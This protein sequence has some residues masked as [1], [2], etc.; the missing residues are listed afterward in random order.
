MMELGEK[1]MDAKLA[2]RRIKNLDKGYIYIS[3]YKSLNK[4]TGKAFEKLLITLKE[5][6]DIN[7]KTIEER[8]FLRNIKMLYS[9]LI[10]YYD[11]NQIGIYDEEDFIQ[12]AYVIMLRAIKNY[13]SS[14]VRFSSYLEKCLKNLNQTFEK[15]K[16]DNIFESFQEELFPENVDF[17]EIIR[18]NLIKEE[19]QKALSTLNEREEKVIRLRFGFYNDNSLTQK[20]V[21]KILGISSGRVG[22]IEAKALRKLRHPSRSREIIKD[23]VH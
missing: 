5:N 3:D 9:L 2:Y 15:A 19:I 21:A 10:K 1:K 14:N 22:Q 13:N 17:D 12:E 4:D 11:I 8:F 20:E 6:N 16:E 7:L 23:Y 18:K